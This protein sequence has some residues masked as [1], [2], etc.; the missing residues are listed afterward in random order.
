MDSDAEKTQFLTSLLILYQFFY[1]TVR[2]WRSRG[3]IDTALVN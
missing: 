2:V 3:Y 1:S